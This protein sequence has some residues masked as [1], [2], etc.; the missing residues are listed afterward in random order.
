MF[1]KAMHTRHS[2]YV[3]GIDVY[4][5]HYICVYYNVYDAVH[6]QPSFSF[7]NIIGNGN[8]YDAYYY[9]CTSHVTCCATVMDSANT[10]ITSCTYYCVP[11]M[12]TSVLCLT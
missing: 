1:Q 6:N 7:Y 2:V 4:E 9:G 8:V 5:A 3:L 12:Y 11:C 10:Y